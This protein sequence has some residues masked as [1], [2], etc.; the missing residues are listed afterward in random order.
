[1]G[2]R[3]QGIEGLSTADWDRQLSDAAPMK[4]GR[5]LWLAATLLDLDWRSGRSGCGH[6]RERCSMPSLAVR[7]RAPRQLRMPMAKSLLRAPPL[8]SFY[9][10]GSCVKKKRP[11]VAVR[12]YG[13]A[14]LTHGL[15]RKNRCAP[16]GSTVC[17]LV[18]PADSVQGPRT[19]V[20]SW[21]MPPLQL[22]SKWAPLRVIPMVG[23]TRS[24]L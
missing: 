12:S 13:W 17:G 10:K 18:W 5:A 6:A 7:R 9:K 3:L 19:L 14:R 1:V 16:V 24:A 23:G 15:T 4:L 21:R 20:A 11:D 2:V 8:V 22:I